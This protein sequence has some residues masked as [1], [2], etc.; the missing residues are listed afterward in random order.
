M[1]SFMK[2]VMEIFWQRLVYHLQIFFL[3]L[4][5]L[6]FEEFRWSFYRNPYR[7][8]LL[9]IRGNPFLQNRLIY[10][11][12]EFE[13]LW[14]NNFWTLW[15]ISPATRKNF[16]KKNDRNFIMPSVKSMNFQGIC[17]NVFKMQRS[18]RVRNKLKVNTHRPT[19]S[20]LFVQVH[21]LC[22]HSTCS[23]ICSQTFDLPVRKTCRRED[24]FMEHTF[25]H[26][27]TKCV[28]SE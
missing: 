18:P 17:E 26:R 15:R 8:V 7:K 21:V 16:H 10:F 22:Y 14:W 2:S 24:W 4:C 12:W 11:Y 5:E 19:Y 28:F 13:N 23:T 9:A 27:W 3:E 6:F 25:S 20:S 1:K